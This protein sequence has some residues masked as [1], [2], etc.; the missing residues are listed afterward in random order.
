MFLSVFPGQFPI[1]D[2]VCRMR[3][4][5]WNSAFHLTCT[6]VLQKVLGGEFG[7]FFVDN[8][9][10][11]DSE[12]WSIMWPLLQSVTVLMVMSLAPGRDRAEDIF[13]AA[14]DSTTSERITCLRLEG[15]KAS[16]VVRKACQELGV[17]SIPREL[18]RFLIQ[19]S[20]GIPYY[21]EELLRSL[22]C[23]NML[24]LHTGRPKEGEDSWQSLMAKASPA[25]TAASSP[26]S[27]CDGERM[28]AIR[29]DVNLETSMLPFALKEIALAELDRMDLQKQMVLKFAAII[30]PVFTTQQL[31]HI[32][33][34][35]VNQWINP[36]LDMLVK[37]NI[38]KRLENTEEPED[39]QGAPEGPATSGQAGSGVERPSVN[40]GSRK[41]QSDVLAFCAPLLWEA[42]YELWPTR[43]RVNIHRQCAAFLEKHAHKCQRCHGGDFVAFHRFGVSSPQKQGSCQGSA[44]EDDWCSWEALVVAGEHLRRART[45]PA[46]GEIL[47]EGEQT[48]LRAEDGGECSCQCEAIAEAVLVPLARHYRAMGSTS[49]ALYYVLECAAAYLHVS[50]S[51][52]A[53]MKLSEAE[54]L[55][56]S[57]KKERNAIDRFEEAI[58]FSLKGE[59]CSNVGCVKLAK[60]MSRQALRLLEKRFPRTRA[61]AFVK[62]LW[63]GLK[64]APQATGRAS[65]LPQEARRKK[66]AWLVQRSRCLSLLEDL[67]S[68]EGTSGGQRFSRLAALMKANTD[69]KMHSYQAA[70]SHIGQALN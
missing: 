3:H 33:P 1:T 28:C 2:E 50:N 42:T 32:L 20:S 63:E 38:L 16:D 23:N 46:E 43:E 56:S 37:D 6:Q 34:I 57:V 66:Q 18:A 53:L 8:A 36:L 65:F 7:I 5:E 17:R 59:V 62:S 58:F 13:K 11:V 60:E 68:Q 67:Y 15:L 54:A 10:F 41:Q 27:G 12:S 31:V 19:R 30:G 45:H 64:R 44:D 25:V 49:Q 69:S 14:T 61:G 51:Y 47:A 24:L 52:M 70:D 29:P 22:R 26:G 35:S 40:T 9:H 55:R 48:T 39:V 4:T 21:C